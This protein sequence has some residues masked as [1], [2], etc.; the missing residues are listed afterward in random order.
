MSWK[1]E[2]SVTENIGAEKILEVEEKQKIKLISSQEVERQNMLYEEIADVE[3]EEL[4]AW[5]RQLKVNRFMADLE[6]RK[7]ISLQLEP[8]F[9][10]QDRLQK[11]MVGDMGSKIY[12]LGDRI[13]ELEECLYQKGTKE[14]R[15]VKLEGK[16]QSF[17]IE[18]G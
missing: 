17:Q 2:K 5:Q 14:D 18:S 7:M 16:I 4:T 12:K 1:V 8:V 3:D 10:N 13:D 11:L 6:I 15:F 9:E